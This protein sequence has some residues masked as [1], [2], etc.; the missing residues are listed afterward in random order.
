MH[1][2]IGEAVNTPDCGSG[3]R[4]FDPHISPHNVYY[5]KSVI[6]D[7][8]I[9]LKFL[10][11]V[12]RKIFRCKRVLVTLFLYLSECKYVSTVVETLECSIEWYRTIAISFFTHKEV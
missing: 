10:M 1:G 7:W 8:N 2:G 5:T 12:S 4:G 3:T 6:I 11:M 9:F